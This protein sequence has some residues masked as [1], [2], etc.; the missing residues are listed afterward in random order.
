MTI[1]TLRKEFEVET[2][3]IWR[4][5]FIGS[6]Y[7]Y[8]SDWLTSRLIAVSAELVMERD[9]AG[10]MREKHDDLIDKIRQM[11]KEQEKGLR[12]AWEDGRAYGRANGFDGY[13]KSQSSND[14]FDTYLKSLEKKMAVSKPFLKTHEES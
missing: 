12:D 13:P 2:G 14:A 1:N 7:I 8:Y 11:Q 5:G 3:E 9:Y 4:D 6:Y 10:T